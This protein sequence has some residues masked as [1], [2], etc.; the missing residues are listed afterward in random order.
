MNALNIVHAEQ[1]EAEWLKAKLG[2]GSASCIYDILPGARGYKE[3][4]NT[5]MMT[6]VGQIATGEAD[7]INAKALEWGKVNESAARAAYAFETGETVEEVGFIYGPDKRV[8][9]S[10]DGLIK[11]KLKGLEIKNPMTAK[12]HVDFL[13]NDKVR[14]EYVAQVQFSMWVTG[15]EE[16]D[17]CSFHPKFKTNMIGIKTFKRDPEWMAIFD[18]EVPLFIAEMD[19]MLKKLGLVFGSQWI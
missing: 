15:Y 6:L 19:E 2:V 17:F 3:A 10:P 1:G 5:Y 9:C 14:P 7:E 16:W 4:R 13:A 18:K 11:G 12:V 8:G